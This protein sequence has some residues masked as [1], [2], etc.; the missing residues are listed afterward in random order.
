VAFSLGVRKGIRVI[1]EVKRGGPDLHSYYAS[2]PSSRQRNQL[3][4]EKEGEAVRLYSE[5][6]G[7]NG[8]ALLQL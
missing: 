3:S 7:E 4:E 6:E 8:D 2:L 5:E 1:S